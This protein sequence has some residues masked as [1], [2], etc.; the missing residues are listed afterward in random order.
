MAGTAS[1]AARALFDVAQ[2]WND[3]TDKDRQ[4]LRAL[5]TQLVGYP[6]KIACEANGSTR[7][8]LYVLSN[9]TGDIEDV[10]EL[11]D[12][13][14]IGLVYDQYDDP[15][16]KRVVKVDDRCEAYNDGMGLVFEEHSDSEDG[17]GEG[18]GE[19]DSEDEEEKEPEAPKEKKD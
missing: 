11:Q 17:E 9:R 10:I 3:A 2:R 16:D 6:C 14:A 12:S 13:G 1:A 7:V 15:D 4:P 5:V 8:D 19:G 18:D